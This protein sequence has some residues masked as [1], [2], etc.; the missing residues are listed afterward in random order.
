VVSANGGV[1]LPKG[2]YYRFASTGDVNLVM[3]RMGAGS[4]SR[5]PGKHDERV[6]PDGR[7]MRNNPAQVDRGHITPVP[8]GE[9]FGSDPTVPVVG[10]AI[11]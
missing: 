6:G 8:T 9:V 7:P 11:R 1:L 2:T 4:N 3:L 10:Q 5:Q